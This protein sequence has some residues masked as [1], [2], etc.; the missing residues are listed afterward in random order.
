MSASQIC[1]GILILVV[2]LSSARLIV[3]LK[4]QARVLPL[5]FVLL[6]Q[7]ASAALLY[8]TL[9]PPNRFA[10]AERLQILTANA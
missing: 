7:G 5:L 3:T 2:L 6:L 1:V 8:F 9:F 4:A 10:V